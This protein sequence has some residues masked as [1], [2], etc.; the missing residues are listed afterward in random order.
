M[1]YFLTKWRIE[2]TRK[3]HPDA[4][5]IADY[6]IGK[7]KEIQYKKIDGGIRVERHTWA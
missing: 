6:Y 3:I 2:M 4:Q 1:I 7:I 5:I